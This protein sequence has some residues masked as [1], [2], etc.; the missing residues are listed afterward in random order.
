MDPYIHSKENIMR[1]APTQ[2]LLIALALI[3]AHPIAHATNTPTMCAKGDDAAFSCMLAKGDKTVS[4]CAKN[5]NSFYYAYG[6]VGTKPD[7]VWPS[8]DATSSGMTRTHLMFAGSTGGY[9]FAFTNEGFKYVVYSIGGTQ[10]EDGG[11]IVTKGVDAAPV[12]STRCKAGTITES[13]SEALID[14]SLKLP[15]DPAIDQNGLPK[16]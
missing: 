13:D 4:I 6:K 12:K 3:A 10:F 15:K 1:P 14:A 11:I 9:A 8:G 16:H 7:M 2:S 5:R